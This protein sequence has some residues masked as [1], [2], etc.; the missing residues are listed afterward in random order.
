MPAAPSPA[1]TILSEQIAILYKQGPTMIVV[2]LAV[3]GVLLFGLAGVVPQA[4]LIGWGLMMVTV[5]AIRASFAIMYSM[6]ARDE[7]SRFYADLFVFGCALSGVVWAS[8][9]IMFFQAGAVEYQILMFFVL[10][11]MAAGSVTSLYSY[12]PAFYAYFLTSFIP[13]TIWLLLTGDKLYFSLA[14]FSMIFIAGLS[15]M[16]LRLNRAL[17]RSLTLRTTNKELEETVSHLNTDAEHTRQSQQRLIQL[18]DSNLRPTLH[19]LSLLTHALDKGCDEDRAKTQ[20]TVKS[21]LNRLNFR[22]EA[23]QDIAML[24]AGTLKPQRKSFAIQ[25]L[26]DHLAELFSPI[27]QQKGL[28]LYIESA[29][30]IVHSD[31]LILENA[32]RYFVCQSLRQSHT[33]ELTMACHVEHSQV[34]LEIRNSDKNSAKPG[35]KLQAE[36]D[37]VREMVNQLAELLGH[38]TQSNTYPGLG[39]VYRI[40]LPFG[41]N[42]NSLSPIHSRPPLNAAPDIAPKAVIALVEPDTV[43]REYSALLFKDRGC[44]VIA[45]ETTAQLLE[46]LNTSALTPNTLIVDAGQENEAESLRSIEMIRNAIGKTLLN[47][48]ITTTNKSLKLDLGRE[49]S[50]VSTLV[51]PLSGSQL[52]GLIYSKGSTTALARPEVNNTQLFIHPTHHAD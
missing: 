34:V 18:A 8:A 33:G 27:A 51:K 10:T 47:C 49:D 44:E 30:L 23:L 46:L 6:R 22:F 35:S 26:M 9:S 37:V 36:V 38:Q 21:Y 31:P 41:D 7:F 17:T 20:A 5:C 15:V 29:D 14:V 39:S 48:Y 43:A 40:Y 28:T 11:G 16:Y 50:S 4:V 32:L 42:K 13:L 2:N 1:H 12:A 3:A 19:S 25:E 24:E 52:D 45:T